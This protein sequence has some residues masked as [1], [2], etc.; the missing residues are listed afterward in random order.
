MQRIQLSQ[1]LRRSQRSRRQDMPLDTDSLSDA[2]LHTPYSI[3]SSASSTWSKSRISES[4]EA[5]SELSSRD[6]NLMKELSSLRQSES[7]A[8]ESLQA[9][10]KQA[11]EERSRLNLEISH[12]NDKMV[13]RLAEFESLQ[14]QHQKIQS[15]NQNL[16][17]LNL[18]HQSELED[19]QQQ[20]G[21]AIDECKMLRSA[22]DMA[23]SKIKAQGSL[24]EDLV[25]ELTKSDVG[26]NDLSLIVTGIGSK[27]SSS[28]KGL[29]GGLDEIEK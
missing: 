23:E 15:E 28:F 13:N 24:A 1:L 5:L 12:L 4:G 9:A 17:Q 3:K 6:D 16:L 21:S 25:G 22:L 10:I 29:T 2:G 20:L 8:N 14:D 11:D 19:S 7:A 18:Q 26:V 27:H